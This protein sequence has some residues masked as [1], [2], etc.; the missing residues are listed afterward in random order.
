MISIVGGVY[1]ERCLHPDYY[2]IAGSG[3]RAAIAVASLECQVELYSYLDDESEDV[4]GS[5]AFHENFILHATKINRSVGFQYSHGLSVPKVDKPKISYAPITVRA[6]NIIRFGMIEGDAVIDSDYAVYDPQSSRAPARFSENGSKANHLALVLN[7]YEAESMCG[8]GSGGS[9]ED[10]AKLLEESEQAEVVVIKMGPKGA[11]VYSGGQ[12]TIVPVFETESVWKIGSG[13]IFV[14][15][16]G[17]AWMEQKL[18]PVDAASIASK[19]TAYYCENGETPRSRWL[20]NYDRRPLRLSQKFLEG[21]RPKIYLAGPFFSLAEL[22]LVEET[23]NILIDM[24]MDVFSPYHDVGRGDAAKVVGPDL[25]GI[26][27]C[28]LVF[29]IGDGLDSGTIFELGYAFALDDK[30]RPIVLYVESERN[31]DLKMMEGTGCIICDDYV[32]AIYKATW[33]AAGL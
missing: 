5:H 18:N 9:P 32:T 13:D 8:G 10:L 26:K 12:S 24:G 27:N 29:A 20:E 14:A 30:R 3:G 2:K 22:W 19:A 21:N 11:L 4:F 33:I 25:E 31:E 15:I 23:R 7:L 28:D 1:R 17:H 16:F 6:E